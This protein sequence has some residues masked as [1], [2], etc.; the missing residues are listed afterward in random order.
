MYRFRI[1]G[2]PRSSSAS[3]DGYHSSRLDTVESIR[4]HDGIL[5]QTNDDVRFGYAIPTIID[6]LVLPPVVYRD[7]QFV[8]EE[9]LAGEEDY[10][11]TQG[12]AFDPF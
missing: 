4:I 1:G 11:M 7:G 8:E 9:P 10:T 12:H 3:K 6:E 2:N 5:P